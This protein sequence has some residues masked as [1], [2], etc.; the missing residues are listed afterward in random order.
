MIEIIKIGAVG[1]LCSKSLKCFG[2]KE[3]S[4]V[5][6]FMCFLYVGVII[7]MKIGGWYTGFMDSAFMQLMIKIFG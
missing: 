1:F 6:G 5:I 7:Y 3:Y 2:K 4:D